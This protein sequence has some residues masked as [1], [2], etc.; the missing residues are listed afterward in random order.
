M[1][2]RFDQ[3][4]FEIFREGE[5]I[6]VIYTPEILTDFRQ[7]KLT[8]VEAMLD[9]TC[10]RA[11]DALEIPPGADARLGIVGPTIQ[12]ALKEDNEQIVSQCVLWLAVRHPEIW[13]LEIEQGELTYLATSEDSPMRVN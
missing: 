9:E 12:N 13:G 11:F 7:T 5:E 10:A 3:I 1:E 2:F 8:R 6:P 4:T